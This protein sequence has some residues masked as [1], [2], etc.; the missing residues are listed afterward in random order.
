MNKDTTVRI[1]LEDARVQY[2]RK[3]RNWALENPED[4]DHIE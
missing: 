3:Y 2:S 4:L 1:G